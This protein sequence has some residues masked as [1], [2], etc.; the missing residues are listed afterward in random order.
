MY[1]KDKQQEN[2]TN[3]KNLRLVMGI[4]S[5]SSHFAHLMTLA[6][7]RFNLTLPQ[8]NVLRILAHY[9][10]SPLP[11]YKIKEEMIDKNSNTSRLIDKLEQKQFVI[12]QYSSNDRRVVNIYLTEMG[13]A[14][15]M[16]A[17]EHL[18]LDF[19]NKLTTSEKK[20]TEKLLALLKSLKGE[21][22]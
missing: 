4:L 19:E 6:L 3:D 12:K 11:L 17:S 8:F 7:R 18:E 5:I 20:E 9:A 14:K 16:E 15:L 10:P 13:K 1:V 2:H 22:E 21:K